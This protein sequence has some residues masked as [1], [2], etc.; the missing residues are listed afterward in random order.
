MGKRSV[1]KPHYEKCVGQTPQILALQAVKIYSGVKVVQK[2]NK[3]VTQSKEF[4]FFNRTT[5][6]HVEVVF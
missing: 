1:R 4:R 2:R 5:F 3:N 6:I